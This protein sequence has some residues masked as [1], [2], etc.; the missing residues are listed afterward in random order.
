[1]NGSTGVA[2]TKTEQ[3]RDF[4]LSRKGKS[5][6]KTNPVSDNGYSW[7]LGYEDTRTSMML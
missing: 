7:D 3:R 4:L 6:M 1:M 5:R 2:N